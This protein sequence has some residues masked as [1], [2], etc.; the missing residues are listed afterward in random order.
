MT[1]HFAVFSNEFDLSKEQLLLK[2][3]L[4]QENEIFQQKLKDRLKD[5]VGIAI[6]LTGVDG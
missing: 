2:I 5:M 1:I 4:K 6:L 3:F